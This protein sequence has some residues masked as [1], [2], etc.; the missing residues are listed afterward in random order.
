[1]SELWF[2]NEL[3]ENI[4][5]LF[6]VFSSSELKY[7]TLTILGILAVLCDMVCCWDQR[8]SLFVHKNCEPPIYIL[9]NGPQSK[10]VGWLI[11]LEIKLK[12]FDMQPKAGYIVHINIV[13]CRWYET[14]H[15]L[16]WIV[17]NVLSRLFIVTSLHCHS[18]VTSLYDT[19]LTRSAFVVYTS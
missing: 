12:L 16:P 10:I 9:S 11:P 17:A 7:H 8:F 19:R 14:L 1:M 5:L 4:R 13:Q 2:Y 18:V 6:N 3:E 15:S